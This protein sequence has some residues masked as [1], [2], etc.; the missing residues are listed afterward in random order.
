MVSI[1]KLQ[2]MTPQLIP[3]LLSPILFAV[4]VYAIV[5]GCRGATRTHML[6]RAFGLVGI[7]LFLVALLAMV[8]QLTQVWVMRPN[9]ISVSIYLL[10]GIGFIACTFLS[11]L[12]GVKARNA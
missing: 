11:L 12:F 10:A 3:L 6:S 7:C 9:S 2:A 5:I 4:N 8:D 1:S